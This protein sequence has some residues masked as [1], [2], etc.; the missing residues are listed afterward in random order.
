MM[1]QCVAERAL[2]AASRA[3]G[4]EKWRK[5]AVLGTISSI[6]SLV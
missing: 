1:L 5:M 2:P 4:P 3:E 6:C